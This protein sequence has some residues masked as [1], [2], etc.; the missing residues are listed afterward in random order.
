MIRYKKCPSQPFGFS[1]GSKIRTN[2]P[3]SPDSLSETRSWIINPPYASY[4]DHK[5]L[6]VANKYATSIQAYLNFIITGY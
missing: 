4:T 6:D 2:T 3:Q 5:E 1:M